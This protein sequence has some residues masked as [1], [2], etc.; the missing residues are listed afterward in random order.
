MLC[1]TA[2]RLRALQLRALS[3][4]PRRSWHQLTHRPGYL[5]AFLSEPLVKGLD[6]LMYQQVLNPE[7]PDAQDKAEVDV[8]F[9][10]LLEADDRFPFGVGPST[11]AM[12]SRPT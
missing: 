8:G 7:L 2:F 6:A 5:D 3:T 12:T 4:R 1:T 10:E 11:R 9:A